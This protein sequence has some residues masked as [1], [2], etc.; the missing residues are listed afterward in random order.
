MK[1]PKDFEKARVKNNDEEM[2][3]EIDLKK[4]ELE[5]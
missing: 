4:V 1:D 5:M 3:W 2:T